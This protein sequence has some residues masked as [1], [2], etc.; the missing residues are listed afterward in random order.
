MH[1]GERECARMT[2]NRTSCSQPAREENEKK[3][4]IIRRIADEDEEEE[5]IAKWFPQ[6]SN[7][8]MIRTAGP[9][10]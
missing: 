4:E 7:T 1:L 8:M 5:D 3:S 2:V 10:R 9:W 6:N